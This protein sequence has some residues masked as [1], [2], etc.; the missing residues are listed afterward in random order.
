MTQKASLEKLIFTL[1][2]SIDPKGIADESLRQTV[3]LLLNLVAQINLK[4]KEL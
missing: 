2:Q 3:E 1:L 4:I